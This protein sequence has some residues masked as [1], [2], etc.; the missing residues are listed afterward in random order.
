[1]RG[2][3]DEQDGGGAVVDAARVAG[4]DGAA[5]PEGRSQPREPVHGQPR[6]GPVV[7]R[8]PADLDDLSVEAPGL[9]GGERAGVRPCGVGVLLLSGHPVRLGKQVVRQPHLG[10]AHLD[11]CE[12][13]T[14]VADRVA[15]LCWWPEPPRSGG[16]RLDSPGKDGARVGPQHRHCRDHGGETARALA[17]HGER[18][19]ADAEAGLQGGDPGHVAP[20]A[21]AVAED[22]LVDG[23]V[24]CCDVGEHRC[25]EVCRGER[26]ERPSGRA[27][28]GAGR[29]D[30]DRPAAH[31]ATR[32]VR[33]GTRRTARGPVTSSPNASRSTLPASVSG[34]TGT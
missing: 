13:R 7:L 34:T 21:H 23:A 12:R 28:G 26:G 2:L 9:L 8:H 14:L 3:V 29:G 20:G 32:A 31:G 22:H 1:V 18:R 25:C 17:V 6:P 15:S 11:R 4:R 33:R 27:D 30:D 10:V 5:L 24:S 16:G 19:Y